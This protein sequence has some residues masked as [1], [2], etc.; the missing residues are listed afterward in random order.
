M[1]AAIYSRKS[2]FTGKGDSIE[3]QI[4]LCKEYGDKLGVSKYIIYEDEGFS[5]G[6]LNRP[7]FQ[8][9][10]K[11][12]KENKFSML[13]CYRLDRISRNVA[14]FS[15]T[16]ELLQKHDVS[17]IS[18][19]EQFDTTTPMG[20]AMVYISSVFAQLERETIAERIK[21]NMYELAKSGRWLG[22]QS[23][24]G[25]DSERE[26]YI[27]KDCKERSLVKLVPNEDELK[28]VIEIFNLYFKEKSIKRVLK[29]CISLNIKGKNGGEMYAMSIRDI[30]RN[31]VYVKANDKVMKYFEDKGCITTG[32]P[33]GNGLLT[34][35]KVSNGK[36]IPPDNWIVS[37]SKH[38]GIID[39]DLW[40]DV[41][42]SL[43]DCSKLE[44]RRLGTSEKALLS[45]ILKCSVCGSPM[46]VTYGRIK[47]NGERIYYYMCTRKARY[48][49]AI[50]SNP[51]A[52]GVELELKILSEIYEFNKEDLII[53]YNKVQDSLVPSSKKLGV[54]SKDIIQ[55]QM[56]IKNLLSTLSLSDSR[57][58]EYILME[59]EKLDKD[60]QKL[61]VEVE[62][63]KNTKMQLGINIDELA[64]INNVYNILDTIAE[65]RKLMESFIETI[66][67]N[68]HNY[69]VDINYWGL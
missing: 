31:P 43:D 7:R 24:L 66:Y 68:G 8:E 41:Q 63:I 12:L 1:I 45:G 48:G 21:D 9:L 51:N 59:I 52:P 14:D 18:I 62:D 27:D 40:L 6:T 32:I 11:D 19:K 36:D 39:P 16:L 35:A 44:K 65:K 20:R 15:T 5:G 58:S 23:P 60:K 2:K 25:F 54:L 42:N 17:F 30:L 13:I 3:N 49:K 37:C 38:I 33:T 69:T 56:K 53:E 64:N 50:C 26:Y 57:V 67:W 4:Q 28:R 61:M 34:Y 47:K 29:K 46:R 22:G 55:I 10:L